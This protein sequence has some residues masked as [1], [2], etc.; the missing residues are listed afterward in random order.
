[1]QAHCNETEKEKTPPPFGKK[2]KNE[3][4][5]DLFRQ[6]FVWSGI[7]VTI[8]VPDLQCGHFLSVLV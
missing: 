2:I 6:L 5:V 8:A 7:C 3:P 4:K 1:M